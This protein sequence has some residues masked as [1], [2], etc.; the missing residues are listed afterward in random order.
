MGEHHTEQQ[1]PH[2]DRADEPDQDEPTGIDAPPAV[3][4]PITPFGDAKP[5]PGALLDP[6][7]EPDD[8]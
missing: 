1:D 3:F 6:D 8:D 7:R 4:S 5:F 2:L